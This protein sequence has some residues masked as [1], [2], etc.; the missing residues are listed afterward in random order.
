MIR[1]S[2]IIID[3]DD[4]V[5]KVLNAFNVS[6][7]FFSANNDYLLEIMNKIIISNSYNHIDETTKHMIS[8]FKEIRKTANEQNSAVYN[9]FINN[10]R[11]I[12]NTVF[13]EELWCMMV[14]ELLV[15]MV[16]NYSNKPIEQIK[17]GYN[18]SL[19]RY[20]YASAQYFGKKHKTDSNDIIDIE[21]YKYINN[22]IIHMVSNDKIMTFFDK[23]KVFS[24]DQFLEYMK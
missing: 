21:H 14:F 2:G 1:D 4:T 22:D 11:N 24:V 15:N 5:K 10:A 3:K 20:I 18:G 17:R 12:I 6:N 9:E 7:T 16:K 13:D 19:N 23:K 8:K